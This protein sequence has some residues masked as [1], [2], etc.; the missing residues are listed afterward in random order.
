VTRPLQNRVTPFGDIVAVAARGAWMG[1]RG[2]LH[3]E[4][5]TLTRRRWTTK[6]WLTC[7]LHFNDRRRVVMTPRCY[8]ELFFIDEATALAAGH[9]PCFECRRADFLRF[10]AVWIAAHGGDGRVAAI[11][12]ALHAARVGP[13]RAKITFTADL[14]DLPD[15]AMVVHPTA[16]GT[17]CLVRGGALL[18]WSFDG[19]GPAVAARGTV[20]VLTPAPTVRV[21]AAGYV[22]QVHVSAVIPAAPAC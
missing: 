11:D 1:N 14:R 5:R 9:R 10:R 6:A 4:D 12:A 13:G 15:G 3:G 16:P 22:P 2:V 19:Y 18:P 17:A 7:R 8:S 21:L 20:S